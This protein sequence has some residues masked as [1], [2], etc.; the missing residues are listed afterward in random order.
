MLLLS[1]KLPQQKYF[2]I[3][4]RQRKEFLR[5]RKEYQVHGMAEAGICGLN[6]HPRHRPLADPSPDPFDAALTA[7]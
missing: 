5:I 6:R 2:Q 3:V 4:E 7:H 1:I